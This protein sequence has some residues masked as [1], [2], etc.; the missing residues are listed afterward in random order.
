MPV[1]LAAST[2]TQCWRYNRN[3]ASAQTN[4]RAQN[5]SNISVFFLQIFTVDETFRVELE[6]SLSVAEVEKTQ[7][8]IR[9]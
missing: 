9:R 6:F 1:T 8:A 4:T 3:L 2:A 7:D 5:R